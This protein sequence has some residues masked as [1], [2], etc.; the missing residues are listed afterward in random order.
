MGCDIHF[1]VEKREGERWI[2]AD[3]WYESEYR[4]SH[5]NA[6]FYSGRN[7][8]LFAILADVRN[9]FGFAGIKTGEGFNPISPPRGMPDDACAEVQQEADAMGA[10]G[11]SHSWLTLR[12]LLEYDWTQT[13]ELCGCINAP[14]YLEW[15]LWRRGQGLGPETYSGDVFGEGISK[16]TEHDMNDLMGEVKTGGHIQEWRERVQAYRG[17]YTRISWNVPYYVAAGEFLSGTL[18]RLLALAPPPF[19]EGIDLVRT[20]FFFDN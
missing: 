15:S 17:T 2:S 4:F 12:E 18:P 10:D 19:G 5:V 8:Y 7:Y 11:H 16:I 20:V 1:F 13:T 3:T 9:G 6:P 14:E